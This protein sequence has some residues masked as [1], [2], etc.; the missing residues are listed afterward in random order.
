MRFRAATSFVSSATGDARANK[1]SGLGHRL[2]A[3][4]VLIEPV[5]GNDQRTGIA[6]NNSANLAAIGSQLRARG[7]K[8]I[9]VQLRPLP[10]D[11]LQDDHV[12]DAGTA[13]RP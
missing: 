1:Q 9:V 8:S 4:L 10:A 3:S 6:A 2:V 12:P 13:T 11:G 7:I 5:I